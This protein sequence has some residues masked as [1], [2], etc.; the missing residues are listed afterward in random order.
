MNLLRFIMNR[1]LIYFLK[2]PTI[3]SARLI[4]HLANMHA[5]TIPGRVAV[6]ARIRLVP[7]AD[8]GLLLT[9][10]HA[11]HIHVSVATRLIQT[12]RCRQIRW[13]GNRELVTTRGNRRAT[14]VIVGAVSVLIREV[15]WH[16]K[17]VVVE[18]IWRGLCRTIV[19]DH[20]TLI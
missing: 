5:F 1:L 2:T 6:S 20:W 11:A 17:W 10:T 18:L 16:K 3:V 8:K 12:R 13:R 15:R 4:V 9:G 19:I 14:V 7:M